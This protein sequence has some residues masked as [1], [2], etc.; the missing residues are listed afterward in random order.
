MASK[1]EVELEV[2]SSAEKIWESIKDSATIFPKALPDQY[3]SIEVVEGDGKS[4]GSVRLIKYPP[5]SSP[6]ST[7]KE[8]FELVDEAN[9]TLSYSVVDG[10]VLKY[11]KNFKATLAVTPKGDGSL[12]KWSCEFDKASDEVPNPD[13]I[14]DFAVKNFQDLDAYL[15][16]VA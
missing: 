5:G 8:K 11:Y 4:A 14:K 13:V 6:I 2:K 15:L 12:M 10:D 1:L 16:G 9:K 7:T 3:E